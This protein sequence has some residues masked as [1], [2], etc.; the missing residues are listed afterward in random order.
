M[1]K[2][3][4]DRTR[5]LL[6]EYREGAGSQ[7][8]NLELGWTIGSIFIGISFYILG[9]PFSEKTYWFP[10]MVISAILMIVW[11]IMYS[12][13]NGYT[14]KRLERLCEIEN[15]LGMDLFSRTKNK[16]IKVITS[17]RIFIGLFFIVS[18]DIHM[19]IAN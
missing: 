14:A 4:N 12:A 10:L 11:F 1:N 16:K 13:L 17:V 2:I 3:Q 8:R 19:F 18:M 7:R 6:T 5:I 15:E 9:I